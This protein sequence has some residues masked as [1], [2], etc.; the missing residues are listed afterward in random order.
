MGALSGI[1][2]L[3]ALAAVAAVDIGDKAPRFIDETRWIRGKAPAIE[4]S[5]TVVELW[6]TSC[7]TCRGQIPHLTYLQNTYG[8]RISIVALTT[9]P[10]D[11]IQQ[12]MKEYGDEIGYAVGHVSQEVV[13]QF[14]DNRQSIPY[15]YII[16]RKGIL[17]WKGHPATMD[18][19]L[20]RIVAGSF[21]LEKSKTIT[22]LENSLIDAVKS[23]KF[24]SV[25][26]AVEDLLAVDP[27]NEKALEV[28]IDIAKYNNDPAYLKGIFDNIPLSG[29]SPGSADKYALM[30]VSDSEIMYRYPE[31]AL[32]FAD[33][34]LKKEPENS[35]HMDTYARLIYSLGDLDKAIEWERK[36][37]GTDPDN[38][39]YKDNLE[40]YLLLKKIRATF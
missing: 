9:E 24:S 23:G 37:V 5:I 4:D 14:F 18:D 34:A 40:Y 19:A 17:L 16:D 29:L 1:I 35:G 11:V 39:T 15:S 21:D 38:G 26:K 36:A 22:S 27:G 20:G 33:Y 8:S 12:F 31:A 10:V 2:S 7:S 32:K 30:L 25:S 28:G 13:F 6:K 3:L